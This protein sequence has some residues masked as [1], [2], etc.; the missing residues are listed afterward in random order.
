MFARRRCVD[1]NGRALNDD[2]A[3]AYARQTLAS[4]AP[5]QVGPPQRLEHRLQLLRQEPLSLRL[6]MLEIRIRRDG[7]FHR[8]RAG[9]LATHEMPLSAPPPTRRSWFSAEPDARQSVWML[10]TGRTSGLML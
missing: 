6:Q 7:C 9:R 10:L 5:E 3:S 8:A 2:A 1:S 4:V